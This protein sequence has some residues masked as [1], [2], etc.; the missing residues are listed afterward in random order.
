MR[1][2]GWKL[3]ELVDL[4]SSRRTRGTFR[5][6]FFAPDRTID[7][8]TM[9][10]NIAGSNLLLDGW[11]WFERNRKPVLL[12]VVAIAAAG[13]LAGTMSWSKKQKQ[14]AAGEALSEALLVQAMSGSRAE[15]VDG[16]LKVANSYSGTLSGAQAQLLAGGALFASGKYADAQAQFEK[17]SREYVGHMLTPQAKLGLAACLAAQGKTEEAARAYKDLADR[18]PNANTASQA[19]FGLGGIYESQGKL[20][21]A[22]TLFEQVARAEMNSTLGN[23]AGMRAEE[24]RIKLPPQPVPAA[25]AIPPGA[26]TVTPSPTK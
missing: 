22:L 17:F 6:A 16:L 21:D 10:Q 19:R 13:L 20:E 5:L 4:T 25:V 3:R 2:Y 14:I 18:Y 9:E 7:R 26:P 12:G 15:A 11:I 24:I 8:S 1:V 23:E